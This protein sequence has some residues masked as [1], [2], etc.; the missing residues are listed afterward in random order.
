MTVTDGQW[1]E[2]LTGL[3]YPVSREDLVRR[4]QE[5]GAGTE[6]L[7][8]LRALPVGEFASADELTDALAT[9]A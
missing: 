2:Y 7:Q 1:W 3:D 4:A 9:L 6:L 8:A 5:V